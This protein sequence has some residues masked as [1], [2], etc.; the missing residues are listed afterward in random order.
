MKEELFLKISQEGSAPYEQTISVPYEM[1]D[2]KEL[3]NFFNDNIQNSK[4]ILSTLMQSVEKCKLTVNDY[5]TNMI[6]QRLA[7]SVS[8]I[9]N[10]DPEIK[11]QKLDSSLDDFIDSGDTENDYVDNE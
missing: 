6:D 2:S 1:K 4:F 3:E 5:L 10:S 11:K 8:E 9:V 7:A